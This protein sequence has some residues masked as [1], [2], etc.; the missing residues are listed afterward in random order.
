MCLALAVG[1]VVAPRYCNCEQPLQLVAELALHKMLLLCVVQL[2]PAQQQ[3]LRRHRLLLPATSDT[4]PAPA[5]LLLL[6]SPIGLVFGVE[7]VAAV[8]DG[9]SDQ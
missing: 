5:V 6:S 9:C 2:D 3:L 8:Q 4:A 1:W 7:L